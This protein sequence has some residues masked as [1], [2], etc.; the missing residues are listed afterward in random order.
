MAR[1]GM[2]ALLTGAFIATFTALAHLSCDLFGPRC[3]KAQLAPSVFACSGA[4]IIKRLPL[5]KTA[6]ATIA[7]ICLVRGIATIPLTF[8][9]PVLPSPFSIVVGVIWFLSGCLYLYVF[10]VCIRRSHG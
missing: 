1:K 2:V 9:G 5:L 3:Y 8:Y 4:G 7:L 10:F 6:L